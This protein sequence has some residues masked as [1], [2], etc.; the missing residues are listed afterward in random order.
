MAKFSW[1]AS[2]EKL[3]LSVYFNFINNVG[4]LA[5]V[6]SNYPNFKELFP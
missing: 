1:K 3:K 4:K 6:V 5:E 2:L